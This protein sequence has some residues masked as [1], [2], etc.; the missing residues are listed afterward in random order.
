MKHRTWTRV[1]RMMVLAGLALVVL[2]GCAGAPKVDWT[3]TISGDAGATLALDYA[4]LVQMEQT[5]LT[6]ILMQKSMGEDEIHSWSGVSIDLIFKEAGISD[7]NTVTAVAGDGYAVEVSY[8]EM[9]GGIVAL[10]KDGDWIT[11]VEPDNGPIRLVT[12][13]TPANRWVFQLAELQVNQ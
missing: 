10:K 11:K 8:D 6:D 4:T 12:P 3:L 13:E 7:Y 9:Q 2:A 5:E 1:F